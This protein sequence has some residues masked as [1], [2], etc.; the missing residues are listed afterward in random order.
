MSTVALCIS[1]SEGHM[2]SEMARLFVCLATVVF[3]TCCRRLDLVIEWT[4]YSCRMETA[5]TDTS[6]DYD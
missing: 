1:V 6:K 2:F 5:T 4:M 3:V